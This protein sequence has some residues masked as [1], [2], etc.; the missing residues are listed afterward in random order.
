[1]TEN[2]S[3]CSVFVFENSKEMTYFM[4]RKWKELSGEAFRARGFFVAAL[5]GGNTP[6]DFYI[7]LAGLEDQGIWSRTHIFMADER[8]VPFTAAQ[9]NYGMLNELLLDKVPVPGENCH[10]VPVMEPTI[11]RAAEKYEDHMRNFFRLEG[12]AFPAFDL[13]M[14]GI[15]EDGHTASLFP[16][17]N[18]LGERK[19]LVCPVKKAP[20]EHQRVTLTLPVINNARNIIFLVAGKEKATAVRGVIEEQNPSLPASMI[21]PAEGTLSFVIDHEAASL[22]SPEFRR[23]SSVV[24][25]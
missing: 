19:R 15:G 25:R 3:P 12:A 14:L 23:L 4:V 9:S 22:L 7:S 16:G 13:I 2:H 11:E 20:K 21:R 5:S 8:Y 24:T 1:L 6:R 18:A 17:H 10:P